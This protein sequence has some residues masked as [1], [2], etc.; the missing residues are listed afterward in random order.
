MEGISKIKGK[1]EWWVR[2][3]DVHSSQAIGPF[4]HGDRFIVRFKHDVTGKGGPMKGKR[5]KIDETALYT[6]KDGKISQAEFFYH[7]G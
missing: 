1:N 3:H 4:P 2:T 6:V 7:M 5:M